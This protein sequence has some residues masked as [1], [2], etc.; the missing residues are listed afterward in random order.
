MKHFLFLLLITSSG[1]CYAQKTIEIDFATKAVKTPK[2]NELKALKEVQIV[3]KNLPTK[4]YK[5]SINKTDSFI[6]TGTPPPLFN[7]LS[8]GDGFNS[9]LAGLSG[10]TIRTAGTLITDNKEVKKKSGSNIQGFL[11]QDDDKET[12]KTDSVYDILLQYACINSLKKS[13]PV[14]KNM[15]RSVFDFH[16]SFR[17]KI[18]RKTDS[19]I[20]R[21]NL[22]TINAEDFKAEADLIIR[23]RLDQE[24]FLET[25]F[26]KYYDTI[27]PEYTSVTKCIPLAAADSMLTSYK[28]SFSLFLN[29]Y[30]TTFNEV[31][32]A[33]VYKQLK[34]PAPETVF[35]SL[36]YLLKSDLTKF[37]IEI[38]GI[39]PAKNPQPYNTTVELE[40]HP[41][42]LWSFTSGVFVSGLVNHDFSIRT[43]V[44]PNAQN[45]LKYDTLNYSILK[46]ENNNISAGIN[47]LMHIGGYIGEQNEVGAY[48]AFGPGLT[49]EKT[50]QVRVFIGAGLMFGRTNKLAL[51]F[52]WSGGLVKRLTTNYNLSDNYNPAPA[53]ITRDRF[54]GGGFIS[55]GYSIFG[56]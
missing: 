11:R 49:L 18:I 13:M 51:S 2:T 21:Y 41:N 14:I 25:E 16:Y 5:V 10:Y 32:I 26:N 54:K 4:A 47:A 30:D 48:L 7:V 12:D 35:T 45:P 17:D 34:A 42:R 29:K 46:E 15:R 20:Y 38:T 22:G 31:L 44:Q 28:K 40:K 3:V 27:L 1:I 55:L 9:L 37:S 6:S 56:K 8:F 24:K 43:N 50:P 23:S 52:G 33:K 19:L 53:D 36:P 39:D